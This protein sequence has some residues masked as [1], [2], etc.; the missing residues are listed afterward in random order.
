MGRARRPTHLSCFFNTQTHTAN[1][2]L[3]FFIL[4]FYIL[5]KKIDKINY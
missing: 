2:F 5:F 1:L 3:D 4:L